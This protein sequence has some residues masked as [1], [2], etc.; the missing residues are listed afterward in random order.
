[1]FVSLGR[2]PDLS[3]LEVDIKTNKN[4]HKT[5]E[6]RHLAHFLSTYKILDVLMYD[7]GFIVSENAQYTNF[8]SFYK[9]V[10]YFKFYKKIERKYLRWQRKK[11]QT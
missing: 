8:A 5:N 1:M 6:N 3:W 4:Q 10:N 7:C 2:K 11:L 9:E